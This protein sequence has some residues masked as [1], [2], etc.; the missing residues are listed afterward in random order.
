MRASSVGEWATSI[1]GRLDTVLKRCKVVSVGSQPGPHLTPR[2]SHPRPPHP[3][4]VLE[5]GSAKPTE[6]V[7]DRDGPPVVKMGSRLRT[8]HNLSVDKGGPMGVDDGRVW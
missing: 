5:S 2:I 8:G 3:L 4:D 1:L 7:G 6:K